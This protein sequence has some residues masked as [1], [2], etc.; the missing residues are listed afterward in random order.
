VPHRSEIHLVPMSHP[1]D[2]DGLRDLLDRGTVRVEEIRGVQLTHEGDLVANA[3]AAYVHAD[4]LSSYSGRPTAELLDELPIQAMAGAVG[5]MPPH[6]AIF[7]R[8]DAAG[9][10][11]GGGKRL[12]VAGKCTRRF[13]PEE[14][15]TEEYIREVQ[16]CVSDL[17][18]ELDVDSP[19]DV[20]LVFAKAPWPGT[21]HVREAR[22]R[23]ARLR[24]EDFW[25][26]GDYARGGAALGVALALGELDDDV[27]AAEILLTDR[28]VFSTRAQCSSTEERETVALIMVANS[29]A[30]V[31]DA[32]AAHGVLADGLDTG[33]VKDILRA[34]GMRFDCCPSSEDLERVRYAFLK[35][36]TSETEE[37]RGQ[38]H[39]LTDHP[40]VGSMWWL[41][42]KA[43]VHAA[44]AS[45]LGTT[46]IEVA[47]G[48]EHQGPVGKPLLAV[49]ART[50]G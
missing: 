21:R 2:V 7:T 47:T 4:L 40:M 14:I 1:G 33:G 17:V 5:F 25:T 27:Q 39:T 35:P 16:R 46:M 11:T 34:A 15:G 45:V 29:V 38:R 50:G 8:T 31:S 22:S 44:V 13:A 3:Y 48:P 20:H 26:M 12:A 43:P 36:K 32:V 37:L 49:V 24:S 9:A 28:R 6:A 41:V 18:A 23:G 42:E 19:D 10:E 30:S